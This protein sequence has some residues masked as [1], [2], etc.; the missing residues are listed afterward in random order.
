[1]E[2]K[3]ITSGDGSHTLFLP[4]LNET[5]HS[6]HGALAESIHV[7]IE[8]GLSF[9]A[10]GKN[11]VHILEIGL[12]TGLNA[13]LT[14]NAA[15]TNQINVSYTSL[16][17]FPLPEEIYLQ[18]NYAELISGSLKEDLLQIHKAEWENIHELHNNFHFC[19]HKKTLQNFETETKFD[20]IY[21]DAFAPNKQPEVWSIDNMK[22]CYQLLL[23]G[24][25]LVTYCAQ[26]QF[27]RDLKAAGFV[28]ESLPGPPGKKEMTR[29]LKL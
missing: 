24:G 17:P 13:L 12:G 27:R 19:K 21:F 2:I 25:A 3:I 6:H 9:I 4:H 14:L 7:F 8:K 1:M 23:Q 29:G 22:K 15:K 10:E 11:A 28:I 26:G 16:E 20:L 18:L 5:Y